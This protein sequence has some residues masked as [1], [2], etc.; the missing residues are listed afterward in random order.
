MYTLLVIGLVLIALLMILIV[1]IQESK[2][3]G[4][5]SE[6]DR[7][8]R[9]ASVKQTTTFLE[10]TTWVLAVLIVIISVMIAYTISN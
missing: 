7:K 6:V 8:I 5:S 2:G 4:L 10:K 9:F 1:L 3:G